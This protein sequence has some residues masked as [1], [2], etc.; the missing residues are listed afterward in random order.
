[1]PKNNNFPTPKNDPQ[2][3]CILIP[4]RNESKVIE[5]LLI[6]IEKQSLKIN[7]KDVYIIVEQMDDPTVEI[8][9]K[10]HMNI[11]L[12]KDLQK[13]RKGYALD[14]AVKE[15]LKAKKHYTAYFILDA[16]NI[17]EKDFL[18]NMVEDIS[19]GYDISTGYRNIKNGS[20]LVACASILTFS[21][22]NTEGNQRRSLYANNVTL[23]G[24]GF[25]IKGDIIE[26]LGGFPFHGMTEDYELTLY[27]T[28]HNLTTNYNTKAIFYDEQPKSFKTSLIQRTRWVYGYFEARRK[29]I[30]AIRKS[31]AKSKV[32][33]ASK[34]NATIGVK[35]LIY[36][37]IGFLCYLIDVLIHVSLKKFALD[38]IGI[39]CIIYLIL[40]LV[41]IRLIHREKNILKIKV[42]PLLLALYNPI[43]LMSFILC[44][45]KAI[46][47]KNLEWVAIPHENNT[48]N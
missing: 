42:N 30:K 1:M 47:N 26:S 5:K 25:Y 27:A 37:L 15:I 12:R 21:I 31:I 38:F 20:S 22:I 9:K 35:P 46:T 16:D 39:L 29:Y 43:F 40:F 28:L 32:N 11:V 36:I 3:Y 18:K 4:A 44:F 10:H 14:D 24:T 34:I 45:L 8:A 17:L 7:S 6:S 48:E 19:K 2:K 23:S 41:S 33:Y 13:K